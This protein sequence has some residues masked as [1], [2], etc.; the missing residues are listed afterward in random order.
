MENE[1]ELLETLKD[2]QF[3]KKEI[4]RLKVDLKSQEYRITTSFSEAKCFPS[5]MTV[6]KVENYALLVTEIKDE[7]DSIKNRLLQCVRAYDK[8]DLTKLERLTISYTCSRKSLLQLSK[9]LG[10]AQARIYRIRD[11]AVKKMYIEIRNEAKKR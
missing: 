7:I 3:W 1:K 6:S 2:W 9:D 8:A 5:G 11:R 4:A 10:M